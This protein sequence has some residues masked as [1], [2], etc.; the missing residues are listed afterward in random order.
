MVLSLRKKE[1]LKV[2]QPLQKIMVP[3]TGEKFERQI[4]EVQGLI[5]SEVNVKELELLA[6]G[7][8]ILVQKIKPNFKT[9]G[10]K[11]GKHMKAIAALV[12]TFDQDAIANIESTGG[13]AGQVDGTMVTLDLPDFD[14]QT[15]DIP[16][17]LVMTENELTVALDISL[18]EELVEE[19]IAREFINRIQNM[20]K[21]NGLD[22]TDRI[23]LSIS[24][25]DKIDR[26]I[27]NNLNYI[28]SETLADSL[29]IVTQVEGGTL[30]EIEEGVS[31]KIG[32][33]KLN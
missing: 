7:S 26:A 25:H 1:K 11:Y 28:C 15:A 8:E 14:I 19:G 21:S 13:W 4:R 17:W 2:R 33:E 24:S 31:A 30:V 23:I 12:A 32:I 20:R 10:P 22:V 3:S 9:I 29:Q 18:T 5:L 16:G 27:N 6:E